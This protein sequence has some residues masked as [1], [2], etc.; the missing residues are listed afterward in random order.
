MYLLEQ[1]VHEDAEWTLLALL[2]NA[3]SPVRR[4]LPP[5]LRE[6]A[7]RL[8]AA[9][10]GEPSRTRRLALLGQLEEALLQERAVILWYRWQ[11]SAS[12]PPGLR[13]VSISSLG[14]V[15]YR[16]LWFDSRR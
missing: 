5:E 9:L 2:A 14:W 13:D 16:K 1:P 4:C 12:Y 7:S 10:P 6:M 11:Q 3:N 8:C 15:D